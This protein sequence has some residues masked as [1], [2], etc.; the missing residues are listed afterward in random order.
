MAN[1]KQNHRCYDV[2]YIVVLYRYIYIYILE[3]VPKDPSISV[4]LV[5]IHHP[6]VLLIL[7]FPGPMSPDFWSLIPILCPASWAPSPLRG[8]PL[9]SAPVRHQPERC[10]LLRIIRFSS[11]QKDRTAKGETCFTYLSLFCLIVV[12]CYSGYIGNHKLIIQKIGCSHE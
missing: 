12:C 1:I 11:C 4:L 5:A 7:G 8:S 9:R 3:L 2:I 6:S 10:F